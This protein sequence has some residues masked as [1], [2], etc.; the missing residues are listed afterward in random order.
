MLAI[1]PT[2]RGS[3]RTW[4]PQL[5]AESGGSHA[6]AASAAGCCR[7]VNQISGV[8]LVSHFVPC[9]GKGLDKSLITERM[10]WRAPHGEGVEEGPR[11]HM[12][13]FS[14][15]FSH[16]AF[17]IK[18][19]MTPSISFHLRWRSRRC[20]QVSWTQTAPHKQ[21]PLPSFESFE[22]R[23][24]LMLIQ[25]YFLLHPANQQGAARKILPKPMAHIF[26]VMCP[27]Q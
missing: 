1:G 13:Y 8:E 17:F 2:W 5:S 10:S 18:I 11:L 14:C 24:F 22:L 23:I 9:Y 15:Y 16:D 21:T 7:G 12:L 27:H 19:P 20:F 6:G 26:C 3:W 4:G 25:H